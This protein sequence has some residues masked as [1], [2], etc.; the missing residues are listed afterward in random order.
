MTVLFT[1]LTKKKSLKMTDKQDFSTADT[2][3]HTQKLIGG[4]KSK[5]RYHKTELIYEKS[6]DTGWGTDKKAAIKHWE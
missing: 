2:L 3:T 5:Q 1:A 4:N 6:R